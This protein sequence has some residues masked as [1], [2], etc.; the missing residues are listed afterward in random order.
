[1]NYSQ[2]SLLT[3]RIDTLPTFN[4][5]CL[6]QD[7]LKELLSMKERI[8][9]SKEKM[10]D[11]IDLNS[12]K[13]YK[14]KLAQYE[15]MNFCKQKDSSESN[16]YKLLKSSN[17]L[18]E[19]QK[20]IIKDCFFIIRNNN[21]YMLKIINNCGLKYI[22]EMCFFIDHFFYENT[23]NN[24]SSFVQEELMIIIYLLIEKIIYKNLDDIL[25]YK[26]DILLYKLIK[27]FSY[28]PNIRNFLITILSENILQFENCKN[29]LSINLKNFQTE[30]NRHSKKVGS[31]PDISETMR[32]ITIETEKM[33][34]NNKNVTFKEKI[35]SLCRRAASTGKRTLFK[36]TDKNI[37]AKKKPDTQKKISD[38]NYK[39]NKSVKNNKNSIKEKSIFTLTS[40]P[41]N[42]NNTISCVRNEPKKFNQELKLKRATQIYGE[43]KG[44][45]TDAFFVEKD[46]NL[47][48]IMGKI[49]NI[50]NGKTKK[51]NISYAMIYYFDKLVNEIISYKNHL[52][53][54]SISLFLGCLN[55]Q[56]TQLNKI[57][58]IK[59]DSDDSNS[60]VQFLHEITKI[61]ENY[62]IITEFIKNLLSK[63]FDNIKLL[64][65]SIKYISYITDS[66]LEKLINTKD[67]KGK[68]EYYKAMARLKILFFN[69]IIPMLK[70]PFLNGIITDTILSKTTKN[71]LNVISEILT[72]SV[73]GNLF[74]NTV[75]AEYTIYNSFII[76]IMQKLFEIAEKMSFN[77]YEEKPE[78]INKL[79]NSYNN[80]ENS[81]RIIDYNKLKN[82]KE[83]I[84]YQSICFSW[85]ILFVFGK[86][87]EKYKD[88][89]IKEN[90]SAEEK[91][92]FREIISINKIFSDIIE[93]QNKN[94]IQEFFYISK[95]I[96]KEEFE[97][98]INT[99]KDNFEM[100]SKINDNATRLKKCISYILSHINNI[101]KET[102]SCFMR[103]KNSI[104]LNK[105]TDELK[106]LYYKKNKQYQ[107]T[108]FEVKINK[109]VKI[110]KYNANINKSKNVKGNNNEDKIKP[111]KN[112]NDNQFFIKRLGTIY[113]SLK[114][115]KKEDCKFDDVIFSHI[116]SLAQEEIGNNYLKDEGQRIIFC[117]TYIQNN[118]NNLPEE[119]I[120]NN[121]SKLFM[122]II[123][124]TKII[125]KDFEKN[126]LTDFYINIKNSEKLNQIISN[127]CTKFKKMQQTFCINYLFNKIILHGII[128]E[129][130]ND[131]GIITNINF[132]LAEHYFPNINNI[133]DFINI[134]PNFNDPIS[135][136]NEN[137]INIEK[138][139]DLIETMNKYFKQLTIEIKK[140][141][142]ITK[143]ST[144]ELSSL[145]YNMQDY[146]YS[147]LYDKIYPS[148]PSKEDIFFYKKCSRLQ[149]IKQENL[150]KN[151]KFFIENN[152]LQIA[153]NY[154][155]EMDNK[156][157]PI[158]KIKSFGKALNILNNSMTINSGKSNFG[159]DD[160]LP[161]VLFTIIKAKP[162][163]MITNFNYSNEFINQELSKQ[164][165]GSILTQM[166]MI[167]NIITNMKYNELVGVTEKEF[168]EDE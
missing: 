109:A 68:L 159:I 140:Q 117:I 168:G 116:M 6:A 125:I 135:E 115:D 139:A 18:D 79:I 123:E 150:I 133:L 99:L 66:L 165:Y 60:Y 78:I 138:N 111:K 95:F 71:N 44:I 118:L 1:M 131:D 144:E 29:D 37:E 73:S 151:K 48:Y 22:K 42:P 108:P 35:K 96:Y 76:E 152:L 104:K 91:K 148:N 100:N 53:I 26:K 45:N 82:I 158:E 122:E 154:I 114:A 124:E 129:T 137:I 103:R 102:F 65:Y 67:K 87:I 20:N 146:I 162:K 126:L 50:E 164:Q 94:K 19:S 83:N 43:L 69:L 31:V 161:L 145:I 54:F 80:I 13:Y 27:Y 41:I 64:P 153:I 59:N 16:T 47:S 85:L 89:F 74:N 143:F 130:R 51:N 134:L 136:T 77:N 62:N 110:K 149:F 4:K 106:V 105:R 93:N 112:E 141:K 142:I 156:L 8:M 84:R 33:E 155:N 157:S 2:S 9:E 70:K 38:K 61:K 39:S 25:S 120:K 36:K 21:N 24:N 10:Q 30:C 88:Y 49:S 14:N 11:Q 23:I 5:V 107:K 160:N 128:K 92:I 119:Y 58:S 75:E 28:K 90:N 97:R 121:F 7:L 81:S 32:K 56:Q 34:N 127:E 98:K 3:D 15:I 147:K 113:R 101:H 167:S 86:I 72:M 132:E 17:E 46:V 63:I 55:K 12:F 40:E 52:E 57:N 163:M 166:G